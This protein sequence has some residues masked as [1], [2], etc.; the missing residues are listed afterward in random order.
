MTQ[1][2]KYIYWS[3]AIHICRWHHIIY[4]INHMFHTIID[5][6]WKYMWFKYIYI[7]IYLSHHV[8]CNSLWQLK[9]QFTWLWLI[10]SLMYVCILWIITMHVILFK[11]D[12]IYIHI[13]F[14][15]SNN[16]SIPWTWH[17]STIIHMLTKYIFIYIIYT[18][19]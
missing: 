9:T 15:N 7:H 10:I 19:A 6:D 14:G 12:M 2:L 5:I 11:S 1:S 3:K 18:G 13:Y 17:H 4:N 16:N 8:N